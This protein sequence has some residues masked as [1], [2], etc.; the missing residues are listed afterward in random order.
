MPSNLL[1]STAAFVM[2]LAMASAAQASGGCGKSVRAGEFTLQVLHDG[3]DRP[4]H[5]YVP[6]GHAPAHA[7]PLLLNL[8]GSGGT[9]GV[10]SPCLASTRRLTSTGS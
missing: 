6:T 3:Q 5:L 10:S 9:A 4:V 8:H 2:A 7:M 1:R